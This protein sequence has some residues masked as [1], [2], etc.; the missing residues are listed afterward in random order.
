MGPLSD[1]GVQAWV[2]V[3]KVKFG[4]ADSDIRIARYGMTMNYEIAI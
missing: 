2:D 1:E 4:L 3:E